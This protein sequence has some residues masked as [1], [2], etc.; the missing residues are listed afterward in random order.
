MKIKHRYKYKL[1]RNESI[2]HNCC[3]LNLNIPPYMSFKRSGPGQT[4]QEK[5]YLFLKKFSALK[6]YFPLCRPEDLW[7]PGNCLF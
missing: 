6:I 7:A 5:L 2:E 3:F 1:R 4:H